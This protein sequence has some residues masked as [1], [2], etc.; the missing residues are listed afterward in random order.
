MDMTTQLAMMVRMMQYSKGLLLTN[1]CINLRMG[2]VAAKMNML[3]GASPSTSNPPFF[4]FPMVLLLT[5]G[6]GQGV[7]QPSQ[8]LLL[9]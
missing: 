7:W 8:H 6:A 3:L 1:H 2:L 9:V 5:L 4:R